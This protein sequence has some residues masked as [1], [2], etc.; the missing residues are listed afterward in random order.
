MIPLLA[1][2]ND[3]ETKAKYVGRMQAHQE[4]DELIHG[5][6]WEGGK[7]CAIG[8]TVHSDDHGAY[9]TELGMPEWFAHLEDTIFEGMSV[10]VS[11]RFPLD[12]LSAIP[13]GL[14]A[15]DRLYHEFYAYV[16]R[17][18]CEFDRVEYPDVAAA[19]DAVIRLHE[20]WTKTDEQAWNAAR[21]AARMAAESASW[22]AESTTWMVVGSKSYDRMGDWLVKWF[23]AA[24]GAAD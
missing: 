16:L 22:S 1:Y 2:H 18:V 23:A 12:L 11:R 8:C 24:S 3:P 5:I 20:R 6:Y 13:I 9:E 7:G 15:W 10:E 14:A 19:V 4:A 17:D 21:V